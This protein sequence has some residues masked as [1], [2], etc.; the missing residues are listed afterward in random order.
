MNEYLHHED[1]PPLKL[2][3]TDIDSNVDIDW[4]MVELINTSCTYTPDLEEKEYATIYSR[5]D[6]YITLFTYENDTLNFNSEKYK[7]I[8][9]II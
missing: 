7:K 6:Y 2:H 5:I 8:K 1:L 4:E 3:N 9:D